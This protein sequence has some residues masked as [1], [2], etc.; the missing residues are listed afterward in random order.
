MVK[1]IGKA[2]K[3]LN[4][5]GKNWHTLSV[6]VRKLQVA[7]IDRSSRDM[8]QTVRIPEIT[9]SHEFASQFGLAIFL[10]AK[11]TQNYAIIYLNEPAKGHCSPATSRKWALT[12]SRLHASDPSNSD[13]T[14]G[15]GGVC[16]CVGVR[17]C[18]SVIVHV[19]A[20]V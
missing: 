18:D 9:A 4:R 16:V 20:C 19:C 2:V 7:I 10:C 14:N 13:N 8:S 3:R 15:D 12:A 1:S 11:N 5:S 17:L 6:A